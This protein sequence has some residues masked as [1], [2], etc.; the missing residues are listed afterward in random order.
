MGLNGNPTKK[1]EKKKRKK[2]KINGI[3]LVG[4]ESVDKRNLKEKKNLICSAE[5]SSK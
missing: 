4:I 3:G 5:W 1:K 2:N